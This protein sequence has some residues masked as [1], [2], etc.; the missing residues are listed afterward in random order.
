MRILLVIF[1]SLQSAI[2]Y[3]QVLRCEFNNYEYTI[4]IPND[5]YYGAL[6][7]WNP[8][9]DSIPHDIACCFSLAKVIGSTEHDAIYRPRFN[10]VMW[11]VEGH[12]IFLIGWDSSTDEAIFKRDREI[13]EGTCK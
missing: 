2:S 10:E 12:R 1:I 7:L 8:G 5:G 6:S 9:E 4:S 13:I 11:S 3:G